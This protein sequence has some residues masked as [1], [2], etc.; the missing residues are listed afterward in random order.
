MPMQHWWV[1]DAWEQ[2]PIILLAHVF[3]VIFS[4]V[5]HELAHGWTAIRCGDR[6]PIETGRQ[7]FRL[8]TK[9][10]TSCSTHRS[11][12]ESSCLPCRR[13]TSS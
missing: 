10:S 13:R 7:R 11:S 2:S 3:W 5:L 6:T 8:R 4:I 9:G 1:T 12:R